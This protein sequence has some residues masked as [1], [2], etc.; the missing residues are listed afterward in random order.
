MRILGAAVIS[1]E[2]LVMSF[3]VLLAKDAH[4][5]LALSIGGTIALLCILTAG[6]MKTTRGWL[7]GS[8][9]QIGLISYGVVVPTMY[10]MGSLFAALWITAYFLGRKGEA[11]RAKLLAEQ[12]EK[13]AS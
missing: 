7:L 4:G 12:E 13:P 3:A 2:A 11:I 8:I 6:M 10:F 5:W 9:L 1:M